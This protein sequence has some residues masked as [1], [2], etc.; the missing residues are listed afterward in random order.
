M[1]G[2]EFPIDYLITWFQFPRTEIVGEIPTGYTIPD[3]TE[4]KENSNAGLYFICH[5]FYHEGKMTANVFHLIWNEHSVVYCMKPSNRNPIWSY[6]CY[7]CRDN[8]SDYK[9]ENLQSE[10]SVRNIPA[11][12][13]SRSRT[14]TLSS[15]SSRSSRS[16]S[17]GSSS[18]GRSS[19]RLS[20]CSLM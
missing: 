13:V 11:S 7:K 5:T 8:E 9:H 1:L 14:E 10:I 2:V 15:N 18:S 20:D 16:S 3:L 4:Q 17:G 6:L 19:S 12:T